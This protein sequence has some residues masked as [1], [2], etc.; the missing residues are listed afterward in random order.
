MC[1]TKD[2]FKNRLAMWDPSLIPGVSKYLKRKCE[3]STVETK[4][5]GNNVM[6]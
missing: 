6:K 2:Y 1:F 5:I 4:V 3:I